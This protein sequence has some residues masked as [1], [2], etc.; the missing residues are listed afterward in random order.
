MLDL[1]VVFLTVGTHGAFGGS[2]GVGLGADADAVADSGEGVRS[3]FARGLFTSTKG[4]LLDAVFDF[5]ADFDGFADDFCD[6]HQ[7]ADSTDL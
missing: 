2:A 1:A 5:V 6:Y 4:I 3:V 7:P